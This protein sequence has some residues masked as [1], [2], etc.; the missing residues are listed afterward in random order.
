MPILPGRR[1]GPYEILFAIG[2]AGM[3]RVYE[4]E[5]LKPHRKVV[6]TSFEELKQKVPTQKIVTN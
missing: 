1:L 5:G 4:A 6:P 3:D 2:A